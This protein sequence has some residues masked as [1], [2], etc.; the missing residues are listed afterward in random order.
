MEFGALLSY[1][2]VALT[3][4]TIARPSTKIFVGRGF[5]RDIQGARK[6]G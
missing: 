3:P 6:K 5:S 4:R 2:S 1:D